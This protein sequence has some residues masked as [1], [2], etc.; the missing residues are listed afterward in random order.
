MFGPVQMRMD[1]LYNYVTVGR[2]PFLVAH[3][4]RPVVTIREFEQYFTQFQAGVQSKDF[5]DDR[6][7]LNSKRDGTNWLFG[8][9]QFAHFPDRSIVLR[10]GYT[11]DSDRTG[12]VTTAVANPAAPS[13][14]DWSYNGHR[15]SFG[16]ALPAV[17]TLK[18]DLTFDYYHQSY[19]SANSFS[20]GGR[21]VRS[22]N[23]YIVS[24]G[25]TRPI[26]KWLAVGG[27]YSYTRDKS[28][29]PLFNYERSIISISLV[30]TF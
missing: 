9:T 7:A 2:D 22:D 29:V 23:I 27:Q 12:G 24:A 1:Y 15:L 26:T 19:D 20:P 25:V 3:A 28:N 13:N 16:A 8:I 17:Y 14:A 4:V 10:A 5:K 30:G 6:F 18:P 11:F 21:T